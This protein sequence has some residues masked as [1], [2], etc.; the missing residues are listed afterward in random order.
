MKTF[1]F[2]CLIWFWFLIGSHSVMASDC[3]D[4]AGHWINSRGSVLEIG[5]VDLEKGEFQGWFGSESSLDGRFDVTG[6]LG[7][8]EAT[9][10]RPDLVTSL[11]FTVRWGESGSITA[12]TGYC[13]MVGETAEIYSQW[14]L[15]RSASENDFDHLHT[16]SDIFQPFVKSGKPD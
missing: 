3:H 6:W 13:R 14:H 10:T 9:E 11:S 16:G 1:C 15:V 5:S 8:S 7:I 4:P 12:W 2:G